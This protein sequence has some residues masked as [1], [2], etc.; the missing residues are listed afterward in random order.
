MS[1]EGRAYFRRVYM[2]EG[3]GHEASQLP[4]AFVVLSTTIAGAQNLLV[5]PGFDQASQLTGW[6][7]T[8]TYGTATW[9]SDDRSGAPGS[10]SVQHDM[11]N[12]TN[13]RSMWCAQCVPVN[14]GWEYVASGWYYE[15]VGC[16]GTNFIGPNEIVSPVPDTWTAVSTDVSAAPVGYQSAIVYFISWQNLAG[17]PIRVRLDDLDFSAHGLI[18]D[19]G[20]E[21]GDTTAWN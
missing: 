18:F 1:R 17:E 6:S 19:D 20:F 11:D 12:S 13:N 21:S 4:I 16:T 7:C 2:T 15:D 3:S 8:S 9:S 5:N 14:G 10:G